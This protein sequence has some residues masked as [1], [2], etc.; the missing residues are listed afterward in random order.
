MNFASDNTGPAHP[1]IIEAVVRA[2]E[3][4]AMPYGEEAA[5]AAVRDEIREIFEAPQAE[6]A[7][8]ATGTAA[9]G[10]C[11]SLLTKPWEA[12][13]CSRLAHIHVDECGAPEFFSGGAKLVLLEEADAMV[14]PATLNAAIKEGLPRGAHYVQPGSVSLTQVTERGTVYGLDALTALSRTAQEHSLPVHLDGARFANALVALACSPAEMSWKAGIGALSFGG[15]KNGCLGVEAVVLFDTEKA[16]ELAFR[17][18]RGGHL[19]SKHR[20]LS[21]QMAAY[22]KDGLWLEL[23]RAANVAG[24][25]LAKG[26]SANSQARLHHPVDAN[27]LFVDLPR[28]AHR[29]AIS[30]GAQ[31]FLTLED[32]QGGSEDDP[33]TVRLVTNWATTDAEVDRFL[34]LVA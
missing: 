19:F 30:A 23:A 1:R 29:R 13:Y 20:T 6:V 33:I 21:A 28:A 31:Y 9:N 32:L 26:L 17:R 3:G 18:K 2:N 34:E 25:R 11:L 15:T 12:V 8:V 16:D 4:Y 7:L 27:M 14:A 5:M 24:A 10:L 22:L